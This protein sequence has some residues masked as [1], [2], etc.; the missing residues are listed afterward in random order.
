ME[1]G[2]PVWIIVTHGLGEH[3]V[4]H[5]HFFKN[6]S[7]YFNVCLYDL[8]GHGNSSGARGNVG[9]FR[10]F[11]DDLGEVVNFLRDEYSMKRYILFG[12]SMGGLITASYMQKLV[13][14][15]LYPEKVFLSSPAVAATG[16]LGNFF[17]MAPLKFNQTLASLPISIGMKGV[18]D[19]K[20]LSH[21]PRVY[22]NYVKDPLNTLKIHSHLFFEIL[23]H[24]REVFSKPLRVECD[25]Y[26][27]I[28]SEDSLVN[29]PACIEYFER[30]EKQ[31]KLKV[32]QGA[33][34]EMHNEVERYRVPYLKFLE[35]SLMN[36]IYA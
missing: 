28:G 21:D 23:A 29:A 17:K 30:V 13:S 19:L 3:C 31:A 5:S 35:E 27:G 15:D 4:R 1:N 25:L 18:L 24:S 36:S 20:K 11:T 9:S 33:W 22:T 32:F 8:R 2:S 6:F 26:V 10:D 7:Q 16:L 34:H 14:K 12:H